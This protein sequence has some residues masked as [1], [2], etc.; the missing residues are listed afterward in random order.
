MTSEAG[1]LVSSP[2]ETQPT[3]LSDRNHAAYSGLFFFFSTLYKVH[4]SLAY[5][6]VV[7]SV[8]YL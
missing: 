3:E 2:D 1:E 8:V 5:G 4:M 6:A 7:T